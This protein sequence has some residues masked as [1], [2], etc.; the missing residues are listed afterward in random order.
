MPRLDQPVHR[1]HAALVKNLPGMSQRQL[2]RGALQQSCVELCLEL[3]DTPADGVGRHAQPP[4]RFGKAAAA[5]HLDKQ[6]NV[7]Q[8]EHKAIIP[9]K[10]GRAQSNCAI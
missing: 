10:N 7:I 3:L 1:A 6:G 2:A 5:D 8:V 4:R 9:A